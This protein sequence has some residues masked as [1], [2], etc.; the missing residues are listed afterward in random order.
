MDFHL[1][2]RYVCFIHG[3]NQRWVTCLNLFTEKSDLTSGTS[4]ELWPPSEGSV[5]YDE[6]LILSATII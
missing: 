3:L 4:T 6:K 2:K 5:C 1:T